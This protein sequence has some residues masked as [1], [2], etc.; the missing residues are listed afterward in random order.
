MQTIWKLPLLLG[1]QS[2]SMPAGSEILHVGV[3]M[4]L[5]MWIKCDPSKHHT[6]IHHFEV[7]GTGHLI[8]DDASLIHI[9][10]VIITDSD[11]SVWHVFERVTK[12]VF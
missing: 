2:I 3:N 5:Y 12:E 9:G 10:T 7:Y 8:Q 11:Y 1:T 4:G 6:D